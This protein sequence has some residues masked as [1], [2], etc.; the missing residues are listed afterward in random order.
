M[1]L[2]FLILLAFFIFA[3][4]DYERDNDYDLK[5]R[6]NHPYKACGE[7]RYQ[8][9]EQFCYQDSVVVEKCNGEEY[10]KESQRCQNN[11]I[12]SKC[13]SSWYN[14]DNANLRCQNNVIESKCGSNWYNADNANLRC[15]NNAMEE[16]C[17][18]SWFVQAENKRCFLNA[19][20]T[21]CGSN[22]YDTLDINNFRC[23][24]NVLMKYC[25]VDWIDVTK[26]FCSASGTATKYNT[27]L[28]DTRDKKTYKTVAIGTQTWMAENLNY[29]VTGSECYNGDKAICDIYGRLYSWDVAATVCPAG[30]RL[31][32]DDDWASLTANIG[33]Y[34]SG[35]APLP[36]GLGFSGYFL[37]IDYAGFWWST[38]P[39]IEG[40]A[41][42]QSISF[43]A[44]GYSYYSS[45]FNKSSL[46][47]VRCIMG[48]KL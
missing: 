18:N 2:R 33:T 15:Q 26:D 43:E 48:A 23:Y 47:S 6:T 31:P 35:F 40:M 27:P 19:V 30:W 3:C 42:G 29:E 5:G 38:T 9:D 21:K 8:P 45:F 36:S 12:E 28:N 7:W 17:G 11:V 34:D 25:G 20:K 39:G 4:A 32:S 1:V 46:L 41:Y 14:A 37:N 16:L 24:N 22:W 13:G 10:E 44:A